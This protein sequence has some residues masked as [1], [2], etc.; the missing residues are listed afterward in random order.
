LSI[1]FDGRR[2]EKPFNM[3]GNDYD[4]LRITTPLF[5]I[6]PSGEHDYGTLMKFGI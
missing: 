2:K 6:Y 4:G 5:P 3:I 1:N